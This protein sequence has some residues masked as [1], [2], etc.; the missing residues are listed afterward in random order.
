MD[1][2]DI[3]NQLVIEL[4]K[5]L[6]LPDMTLNEQ[7]YAALLFDD[8]ILLNMEYDAIQD[9]MMLYVYLDELPIEGSEF[10]LRKLLAANFF[11]YRTQ[12][13]TLSLEEETGGILIS[14]AH[15][16]NDLDSGKF[17]D[18]CNNFVQ[19]ASEWKN[20]ISEMKNQT[21]S[22]PDSKTTESAPPFQSNIQY[23]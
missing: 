3:A 9:R 4:G 7:N 6:T 8:N 2:R 10:L 13:A 17:E 22:N 1:K 12:G 20:K 23:V 18:I 5:T 11:W 14:Y 19:K 15:Q 16:L 21:Q